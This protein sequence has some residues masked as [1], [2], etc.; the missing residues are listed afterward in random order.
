MVFASHLRQIADQFRTKYL[1]SNDHSDRTLMPKPTQSQLT[2]SAW[3][4]A[5]WPLAP[6]LGGPFLAVH[7]RCGDFV[8][9]LT[10][11]WN[12]TPSPALAAKQIAEAAQNQKLDV[13]YLAT[14]ASES[15][16]KELEDELAPITVVRF[17]PSDS[18][19][20]HLGPGE[21][22][23]I[24]QWICA[25]ARFFMGTSP[26]TFTF[27]ITEERTIMG[28]TPES[29]FNTLCASG[30]ARYYTNGQDQVDGETDNCE[31]L[32]FWSIKL[33]PEYTVP[34]ATSSL[35]LRSQDEL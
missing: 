18:D 11:R 2:G 3:M 28:F 8:S 21:I 4:H 19:W 20:S 30:Q 7:W 12:Y 35:P 13:V 5:S 6:A 16:V 26:S 33:E 14:D 24:D 31:A 9:H 1:A 23:I 10:G 29:T 22:A 32:T 17:V 15:D 27:R 25:H 34:S